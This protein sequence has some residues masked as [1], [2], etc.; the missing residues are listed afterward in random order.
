MD[1]SFYLLVMVNNFSFSLRKVG[2]TSSSGKLL[3]GALPAAD[4]VANH[5][6]RINSS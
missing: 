3:G 6:A 1:R 4:S 2:G 5:M